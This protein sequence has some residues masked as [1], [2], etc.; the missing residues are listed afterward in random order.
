MCSSGYLSVSRAYLYDPQRS[1]AVVGLSLGQ[2]HGFGVQREGRGGT[3]GCMA[4]P[5]SDHQFRRIAGEPR[6]L[7]PSR[8]RELVVMEV[9]GSDGATQLRRV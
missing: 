5:G 7:M 1:R 3:P 8:D 9:H 6:R 2:V 4:A